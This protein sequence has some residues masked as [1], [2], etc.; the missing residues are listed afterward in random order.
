[1]ADP[2][3][4]T[5]PEPGS[6]SSIRGRAARTGADKP[7][8]RRPWRVEGGREGGS[9]SDPDK[10]ERGS[11]GMP[12]VP[13]SRRFWRFLLV[14][15]ILNIVFAQL[16]PSSEDRRLDVPYTFFRQQVTAG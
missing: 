11:G 15:L 7:A 9:G 12:R 14:L 8:E 13:G 3:T 16:I 2:H 5:G 4:R 10:P 1:M 6:S